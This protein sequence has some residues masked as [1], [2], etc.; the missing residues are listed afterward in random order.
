[1]LATF[2][3]I[4]RHGQIILARWEIWRDKRA[5]FELIA[6]LSFDISP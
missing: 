5:F 1:M 3:G 6:Q 2:R 4:L